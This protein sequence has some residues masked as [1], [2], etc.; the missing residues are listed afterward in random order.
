M[1]VEEMISNWSDARLLFELDQA[2]AHATDIA[3]SNEEAWNAT[4]A[5][6]VLLG[7]KEKRGI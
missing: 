5:V 6:V 2:A 1:N 4:A 7:E 3:R